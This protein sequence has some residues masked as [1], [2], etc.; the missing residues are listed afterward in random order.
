MRKIIILFLALVAF[1]IDTATAQHKKEIKKEVKKE[2]KKEVK[3]EVY[4]KREEGSHHRGM[5][6]SEDQQK[7]IEEIH[8][9]THKETVVIKNQIAEKKA[10][11]RTLM[12]MEKPDMNDINKTVDEMQALK[13]E[14]MKK[15]LA[16]KIETRNLL[17]EEQRAMMHDMDGFEDHM[18]ENRFMF[19]TGHGDANMMFFNYGDEDGEHHKVIKRKIMM[20]CHDG[21]DE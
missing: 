9:R 6:L 20:D 13:S 2:E 17:T 3:N 21:D 19:R 16:A 1:A 12:S 8:S 4:V 11:L 18:N 15:E 14:V 5:N 10:H 7:K